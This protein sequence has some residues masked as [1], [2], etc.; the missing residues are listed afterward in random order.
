MGNAYLDKRKAEIDANV[1]AGQDA[2]TQFTID[3]MMRLLHRHYGFG[4]SRAHF[5]VT[6]LIEMMSEER[7][8]FDP[9]EPEADYKREVADRELKETFG[10]YF[11]PFD[12]RYPHA[13]KIRYDKPARK[14]KKKWH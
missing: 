4:E 13:R 10:K 9:E 14:K 8:M 6:R 3:C 2:A 1:V 5:L 7:K 12:E 11:N